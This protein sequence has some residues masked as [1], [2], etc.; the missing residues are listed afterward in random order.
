MKTAVIIPAY[1]EEKTLG[2]IIETAQKS[3]L[4][5][6]VVVVDDGSFDR[7]AEI[8]EDYKAKLIKNK[9]KLGKGRALNRGVA[10]S[11]A[12][13]LLFL[14]ADLVNLKPQH[15]DDLLRPVLEQGYDMS[16]GAV[17]R[18]QI[19]NFLNRIFQRVESPFSGMRVLK[20]SF[21]ESIPEKLKKDFYIESVITYLA[22]KNNLNV[23]PLVL[24]GVEHITKE[25]KLGFWPG[26]KARWAMNFQIIFINLVLRLS[27]KN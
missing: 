19:G 24:E 11:Q 14:D 16:V 8:A 18:S 7:T 2:P 5:E 13:V 1:N 12:E 6:E 10:N 4:V 22:K 3:P 9:N 20:R 15:L 27:F 17:D 25:S 26:T 23:F 21:W